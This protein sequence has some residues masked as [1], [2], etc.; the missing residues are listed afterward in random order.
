[1]KVYIGNILTCDKNNAVAKVLVEE[2]GRIVYVGDDLLEEYAHGER[3]ELGSGALIP[4]FADSHTHFASYATFHAGLNVMDAKSNTEILEMLGAFAAT[5]KD[6]LLVAFGASPYSVEEGKLLTREQLDKVVPD[7]PVFMVKYDGHTCVVNTPLLNKVKKKVQHLRGYHEDTGEMNQDAFFGV[8]DYVTGSLPIVK[9]VQDMQKAVDDLA[10]RGIGMI[11]SVSGVGFTGDLDVDLERWF[12]AGLPNGMQMRVYFQTMD[13]KKAVRRGLK[14]IGGCFEAALD[15]CFGSADAAMLQ[16]YEGST[17]CGVLYYT[18]EQVTDF[19]KK[20]NRAGLQIEL[21]AIGDAA[22]QQAT[23][24]MKAALDDFPRAAHRH[25][26]IHA[27]LPTDEGVDICAEYGI[28]LPVQTAFIDWEQ[29]PD[30]YLEAILGERALRLNP[31]RT[32]ADR[33][34]V[35][36]AGSDSPC[37]EPDPIDWMYK[38]CNHSVPEQSLTVQEALRM[39]TYNGYWTSFDEAERGSLEV[40]KI[41]DMVILSENPYAMDAKELHRLQVK[42]L[43]LGGKPYEKVKGNAVLQVLK[44]LFCGKK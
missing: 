1:M 11:H 12:A 41:A 14:R 23:R 35:M 31:L 8:S 28:T 30:S 33:G 10:Q 4:P 20:A 9:L 37:T 36:S 24:A 18:D 29:E 34:I 39:C 43:I 42:Q 22:F 5:C 21:H 32:Y 26:I 25:A 27:C 19:C 6:K 16:P 40:G 44:G 7:R 3:V 17:D 2:K 13:V 15:G 38:A